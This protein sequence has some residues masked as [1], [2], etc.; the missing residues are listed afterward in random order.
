M[1]NGLPDIVLFMEII[2]FFIQMP[3]SKLMSHEDCR[4][5]VCSCCGIKTDKKRITANEELMVKTHA[6]SE[7]DSKV[8]SF[9]AGLCTT[10]RYIK[11][12]IYFNEEKIIFFSGEIC[13]LSRRGQIQDGLGGPTQKLSGI[14]LS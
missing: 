14:N 4:E 9:P 1:L 12:L 7:Y 10:C 13:M 5:A 3:P 2:C 8:Q 6:K 11:T